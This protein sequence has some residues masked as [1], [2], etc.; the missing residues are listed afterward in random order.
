M[1]CFINSGKGALSISLSVPKVLFGSVFL[2]LVVDLEMST[3]K[4][5]PTLS[6]PRLKILSTWTDAHK[7]K[8][9]RKKIP[10]SLVCGWWDLMLLLPFKSKGTHLLCSW[11]RHQCLW[12]MINLNNDHCEL[13]LSII[14]ISL[15][16]GGQRDNVFCRLYHISAWPAI[17]LVE[18]TGWINAPRDL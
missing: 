8:K 2:F 5:D 1:G 11:S 4:E 18:S 17:N 7:K 10:S 14:Q 12:N 9:K 16:T 13:L 3:Q 15:C 6:F